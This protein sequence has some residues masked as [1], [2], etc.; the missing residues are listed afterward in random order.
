MHAVAAKTSGALDGQTAR[1]PPRRRSSRLAKEQ[2]AY[3]DQ[4][5]EVFSELESSKTDIED[6]SKPAAAEK[7]HRRGRSGKMKSSSSGVLEPEQELAHAALM[8]GRVPLLGCRSKNN[9][10]PKR[11]PVSC[12]KKKREPAACNKKSK[13]EMRKRPRARS[14]ENLKHFLAASPPSYSLKKH[15]SASFDDSEIST[16]K[17]VLSVS[18][19]QRQKETEKDLPAPPHGLVITPFDPTKFTVGI[20]AY[21]APHKGNVLHAPEYSSDIFQ[22]LYYAEVRYLIVRLGS[23]NGSFTH[24]RVYA[25]YSRPTILPNSISVK[26]ATRSCDPFLSIGWLECT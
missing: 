1:L 21:D 15:C 24:C 9:S 8:D 23:V 6:D 4:N 13:G 16:S 3:S 25:L 26:S 22:R 7:S 5:S 17:L 14:E 19:S 11:E 10:A 20:S 18:E 2:P 12:K